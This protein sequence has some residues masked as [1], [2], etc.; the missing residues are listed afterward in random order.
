MK[1][2]RASR[3]VLEGWK[4][5]TKPYDTNVKVVSQIGTSLGNH[6]TGKG[7]VFHNIRQP[8]DTGRGFY[9][10]LGSSG[11]PGVGR[12]GRDVHKSGSQGKR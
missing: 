4:P 12:G 7:K 2:G 3:D 1:Q 5:K 10:P 6:V 9:S 8:L 11:T